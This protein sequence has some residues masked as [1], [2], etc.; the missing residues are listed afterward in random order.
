MNFAVPVRTRHP[1]RVLP[2][3]GGARPV[4]CIAL[5]NKPKEP[6]VSPFGHKVAIKLCSTTNIHKILH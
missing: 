6:F 2:L 4:A 5:A 1:I 3:T